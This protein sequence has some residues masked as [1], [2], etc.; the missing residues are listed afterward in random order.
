MINS[1]NLP[2][3]KT[4]IIGHEGISSFNSIEVLESNVQDQKENVTHFC[5]I[6]PTTAET[7]LRKESSVILSFSTH[8]DI[9]GSLLN[10]L[11]IFKEYNIN[12][13]KI[14]SRPEK[15]TLGSYIFYVEF[16]INLDLINLDAMIKSI[17]QQTLFL[18]QLGL[19][20]VKRIND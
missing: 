6:K 15:S 3:D 1:L 2:D 17:A 13:T 16:E 20:K 5:L 4:I 11:E 19:Y 9:P 8:R 10:V 12:L 18:K 14:L 7:K